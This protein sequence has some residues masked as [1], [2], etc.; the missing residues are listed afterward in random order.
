MNVRGPI[1]AACFAA[2]LAGAACSGGGAA[3]Q[4]DAAISYTKIDDMEDGGDL[5]EWTAPR[6]GRGN[7]WTSTDCTASHDISPVATAV[8]PGG[9]SFAVLPVSHLTLAGVSTHAARL[10][11]TAP[12]VGIWGA[13]MGFNLAKQPGS[14]GGVI[15]GT[16]DGGTLTDPEGCPVTLDWTAV[17]VD[18]SA[19]AGITFWAMADPAGTSTI[20]VA[21]DDASTD[22][23]G[24]VCDADTPGSSADCFN[25]FATSL[26]LTD[27]FAP[28]TI[29]FAS[30]QQDPSWGYHPSPDVVDTRHVFQISFRVDLPPCTTYGMCAGGSPSVT[31]DFWI[32][33]LYFVDR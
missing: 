5:I 25:S 4:A 7:W 20:R 22:P 6:L 15:A 8:D 19:H 2:L 23:R 16:P 31:F 9:W 11:T 13:N 10:R 33:D 29:D 24:G 12:L 14:D 30:L 21:V 32:D 27:T 26:N 28:Y 17:P 1:T 18:L 3:I